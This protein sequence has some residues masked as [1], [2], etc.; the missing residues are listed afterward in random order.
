MNCTPPLKPPSLLSRSDDNSATILS[1]SLAKLLWH[2][3]HLLSLS[4]LSTS[5]PTPVAPLMQVSNMYCPNASR[6]VAKLT[7]A[8]SAKGRPLIAMVDSPKLFMVPSLSM[9]VSP[10]SP[11]GRII[12]TRTSSSSPQ[13][14]SVNAF[15]R[16]TDLRKSATTAAPSRLPS[17]SPSMIWFINLK[18]S[19]TLPSDHFKDSTLIFSILSA[20]QTDSPRRPRRICPMT[21]SSLATSSTGSWWRAGELF[22]LPFLLLCWCPY[23][24]PGRLWFRSWAPAPPLK[25]TAAL[26]LFSLFSSLL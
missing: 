24:G 19:P 2:S 15:F 4:S 13:T 14:S 7:I 16:F 22:L 1:A 26:L 25:L 17:S 5:I 12:L 9:E 11:S 8:T 23:A 18:H 3:K 10:S 21:W 20:R 6:T